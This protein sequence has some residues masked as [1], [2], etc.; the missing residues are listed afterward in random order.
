MRILIAPDKFKGSLSALAVAEAIAAGFRAEWPAVETTLA[1][2]SD[3]GEGF[4]EALCEA[5]GGAWISREAQDPI[6]RPVEARYA[7]IESQKL[8][9]IEMSEASGLWRLQTA[10]RDP[11]RANTYGTG[12]LM[13]DAV[14]RGAQRILVGLGG[15]ATT[16]GGV[17]MAAALGY[18]FYTSDGDP[19]EP[20][21]AH[22]LALTR[23]GTREAVAL[24]EII[25]ACDVRNPL[26]GERGTARVF[27]PQKGA[28]AAAIQ[29]LELGLENLAQVVTQDLECDFRETPGAGAAGGIGFGLLSFAQAQVRSGFDLVADTLQLEKQIAACDLVVTGE[30]RLDTQTLEGKGPAG[31]AALARKLGKP[32]VAFAGAVLDTPE[33]AAVFDAVCPIIDRPVTLDEAMAQG[34]EFLE[35]AARR[36]ARW[37][38]AGAFASHTSRRLSRD[39]G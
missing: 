8:A 32:V 38:R 39:D 3:G 7:W 23:I 6:G 20:T 34:G 17:G 24:P 1:P 31:V 26:L 11:L 18:Q 28:D 37:L 27:A 33:V 36:A 30:G 5:L 13:R 15:S 10:E 9:V 25:A 16:D 29:T 12:Q 35:R 4:A 19:L 14:E 2:I 22:L 21:P